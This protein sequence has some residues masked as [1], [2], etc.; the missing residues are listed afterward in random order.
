MCFPVSQ[1]M[2]T[3]PHWEAWHSPYPA[4]FYQRLSNSLKD[5]TSLYFTTVCLITATAIQIHS[6]H[7]SIW[8]PQSSYKLVNIPVN[9]LWGYSLWLVHGGWCFAGEL[10]D[11]ICT[12]AFVYWSFHFTQRGQ[13]DIGWTNKQLLDF[14]IDHRS[15]HFLITKTQFLSPL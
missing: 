2:F 10:K 4:P 11:K 5:K 15:R 8:T 14:G 1:S 6:G 13:C 3:P 9:L 12:L 7:V